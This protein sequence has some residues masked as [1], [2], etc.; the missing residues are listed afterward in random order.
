MN[1]YNS[2]NSV[3]IPFLSNGVAWLVG[4]R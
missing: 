2:N 3:F 4:Y 1:L